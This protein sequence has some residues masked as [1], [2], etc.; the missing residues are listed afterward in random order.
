[1]TLQDLRDHMA[2]QVECC[3]SYFNTHDQDAKTAKS[4]RK[5]VQETQERLDLVDKILLDGY[6][7][8]QAESQLN[9]PPQESGNHEH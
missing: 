3:R 2:R 6:S 8:E 7:P 1:M 5:L 9:Q 4:Y